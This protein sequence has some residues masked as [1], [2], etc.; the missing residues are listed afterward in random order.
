[1]SGS[2]VRENRMHGLTGGCWRS[3]DHGKSDTRTCRET[4]RT[5]PDRLASADQPAA[6]LTGISRS[7]QT[8]RKKFTRSV[9]TPLSAMS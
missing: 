6:Y 9:Q 4:V 1:M 5:E 2:R 3:G 7:G 8:R